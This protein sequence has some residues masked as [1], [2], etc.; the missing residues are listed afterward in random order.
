MAF[1]LLHNKKENKKRKMKE[2]ALFEKAL[3]FIS[4][5]WNLMIKTVQ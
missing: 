4:E 2:S 1:T 5:Y 3:F